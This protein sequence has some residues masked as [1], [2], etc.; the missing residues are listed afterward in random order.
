M[1]LLPIH[2]N[3]NRICKRSMNNSK[4][5]KKNKYLIAKKLKKKKNKTK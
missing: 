5:K 1:T 4:T 3:Q 2:I